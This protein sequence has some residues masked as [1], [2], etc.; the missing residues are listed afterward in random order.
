MSFR[1]QEKPAG[2]HVDF[3]VLRSNISNIIMCLHNYFPCTPKQLVRICI[4]AHS[5]KIRNKKL[6]IFVHA[7]T[8]SSNN[9]LR[10]AV[11]QNRSSTKSVY[12]VKVICTVCVYKGWALSCL[13]F[14]YLPPPTVKMCQRLEERTRRRREIN[15]YMLGLH[16]QDLPEGL[17]VWKAERRTATETQI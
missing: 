16:P 17:S 9:T 4:L 6:Q 12:P 14:K 5:F 15:E 1:L 11:L 8:I 2:D 13:L 10:S 3:T 7:Q